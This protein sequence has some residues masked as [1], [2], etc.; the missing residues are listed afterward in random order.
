MGV[1]VRVH[2]PHER[3]PRLVRQKPC[4]ECR[5]PDPRDPD[6][7]RNRGSLRG[8]PRLQPLPFVRPTEE[9]SARDGDL[10]GVGSRELDHIRREDLLDGLGLPEARPTQRLDRIGPEDFPDALRLVQL[11]G[12]RARVLAHAAGDLL[13]RRGELVHLPPGARMGDVRH[14]FLDAAGGLQ[15]L[16]L[17]G[18]VGAAQREGRR[19][20]VLRHLD[21]TLIG[22]RVTEKP[23][24]VDEDSLSHGDARHSL[25][26]SG[27]GK[28]GTLLNPVGRGPRPPFL[29]VFESRRRLI[30]DPFDRVWQAS[31]VAHFGIGLRIRGSPVNIPPIHPNRAHPNA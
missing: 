26:P 21:R 12:P 8:E 30:E 10:R 3:G 5:L 22:V 6:E 29:G 2:P 28:G 20:A 7:D 25:R 1:V 31:Q 27:S 17:E 13:A 15:A 16:Q 19:D 24:E 9:G 4:D 11:N 18:D 14:P 23:R